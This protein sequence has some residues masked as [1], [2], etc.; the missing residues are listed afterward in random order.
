MLNRLLPDPTVTFNGHSFVS[1]PRLNSSL[2]C[3]KS[4]AKLVAVQP[5][6]RCLIR[7]FILR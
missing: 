1:L 7:F 6:S 3:R 5:F 2:N 4:G